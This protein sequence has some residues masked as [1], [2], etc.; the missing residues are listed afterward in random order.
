[1]EF[2]TDS[3]IEPDVAYNYDQLG[4]IEFRE[5]HTKKAKEYLLQ[6]LRLEPTL[7]RARYQLARLLTEEGDL[8]R[9]LAE[10]DRVITLVPENRN[11]HYLRGQILKRLG[12][13]REAKAEMRKVTEISSAA[14]NRSQQEFENGVT[15][16]ELMDPPSP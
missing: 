15:D 16:P 6:A 10:I 11:V 1:M 8:A 9:A 13:T 5:Q 12:R 3:Q 2:L 4:A 7:A 14:L